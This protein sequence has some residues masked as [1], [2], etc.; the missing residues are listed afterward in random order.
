MDRCGIKLERGTTTLRTRQGSIH[1]LPIINS[2]PRS[3][4]CSPPRALVLP[5]LCVFESSCKKIREPS[6]TDPAPTDPEQV[7]SP[8]RAIWQAVLAGQFLMR[9]PTVPVFPAVPVLRL[10]MT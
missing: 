4:R 8:G 7:G 10:P 3:Q 1:T 2:S 9:L 5:F 6:A